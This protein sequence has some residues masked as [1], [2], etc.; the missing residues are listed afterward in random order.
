M[1]FNSSNSKNDSE[2]IISF[3]LSVAQKGMNNFLID[4]VSDNQRLE[5]FL[6]DAW[7]VRN[8]LYARGIGRNYSTDIFKN[9][10]TRYRNLSYE[11]G[12]KDTIDSVEAIDLIE[13]RSSFYIK[14]IQGIFTCNSPHTKMYIPFGLYFFIYEAPF[15]FISDRQS[16]LEEIL[17]CE[18]NVTKIMGEII[19]FMQAFEF[20]YNWLVDQTNSFRI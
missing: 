8:S 2:R 7:F 4:E 19:T 15:D 13:V 18:S 10:N 9:I 14:D 12:F 5:V 6:F 3:I 16:A 20:H 1:F 11:F 17:R